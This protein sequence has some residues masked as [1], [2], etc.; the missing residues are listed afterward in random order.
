MKKLR[1]WFENEF[2]GFLVPFWIFVRHPRPTKRL[3]AVGGEALS[4]SKD[5]LSWVM[6]V[7]N[8]IYGLPSSSRPV[9]A[10]SKRLHLLPYGGRPSLPIHDYFGARTASTPNILTWAAVVIEERTTGAK[11]I[12]LYYHCQKTCW[13]DAT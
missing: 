9:I 2:W 12:G 8:L 1:S 13:K 10:P 7:A 11:V 3:P 4:L 5:L 6:L